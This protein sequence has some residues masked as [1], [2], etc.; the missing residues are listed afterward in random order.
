MNVRLSTFSSYLPSD[1]YESE[2]F[3]DEL[4]SLL[5][6]NPLTDDKPEIL[7]SRAAVM[8]SY[9]EEVYLSEE[10][11]KKISLHVE[12]YYSAPSSIVDISIITKSKPG[13]IILS[14][15]AQDSYS[16]YHDEFCYQAIDYEESED[17]IPLIEFYDSAREDSFGCFK[18]DLIVTQPNSKRNNRIQIDNYDFAVYEEKPVNIFTSVV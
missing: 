18:Y 13:T 10:I 12:F 4:K 5:E 14:D 3:I 17:G 16:F 11:R 8:A 15:I 7:K 2:E 6:A 9:L 1:L